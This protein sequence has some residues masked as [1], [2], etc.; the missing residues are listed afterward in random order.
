MDIINDR[1][2]I[3]LPK[4]YVFMDT[5]ETS[6]NICMFYYTSLNLC[7]CPKSITYFQFI[8]TNKTK[9]HFDVVCA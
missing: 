5:S 8:H 3:K 1:L 7:I 2:N 6:V 9:N 4:N